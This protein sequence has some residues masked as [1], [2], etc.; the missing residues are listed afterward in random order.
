VIKSGAVTQVYLTEDISL[1]HDNVC[2]L[3]RYQ[4][5]SKQAHLFKLNKKL[6]ETELNYLRLL[7]NCDKIP[8]LLDNFE[9]EYSLSLID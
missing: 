3:K 9:D 8:R 5:Y 7:T 1:L 6:F 4:H 2:L